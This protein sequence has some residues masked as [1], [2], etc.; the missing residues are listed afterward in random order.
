MRGDLAAHRVPVD[1]AQRP[2][3]PDSPERLPLALAAG[4]AFQPDRQAGKPDLLDAMRRGTA[5]L[6][7]D[8]L[9][10][11]CRARIEWRLV[12]LLSPRRPDMTPAES[13]KLLADVEAFCQ[14]IRPDEELCYAERK[15][16]DRVKPTALK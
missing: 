10:A 9:Y 7:R 8:R 12:K 1:P 15:Y 5:R 2:P 4:Q 16:N 3:H 6:N 11:S 13:Q 14:E